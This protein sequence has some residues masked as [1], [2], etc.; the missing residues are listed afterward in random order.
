M[1]NPTSKTVD[2]I[3]VDK[4]P[5]NPQLFRGSG[6]GAAPLTDRVS[7]LCTC[8]VYWAVTIYPQNLVHISFIRS[9]EKLYKILL[10]FFY[11][12]LPAWP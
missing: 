5:F 8:R 2:K 12:Y 11:V 7:T 1:H 3:H 9:L 10:S 6:T 4:A